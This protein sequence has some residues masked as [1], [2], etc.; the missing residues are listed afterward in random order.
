M[1]RLARGSLG[2]A[3]RWLEDIDEID[4]E[5]NKVAERKAAAAARQDPARADAGDDEDEAVAT[6]FTPGG[7]LTWT[8]EL[9]AQL[10]QLVAGR[11]A[12]SDVAG[13]LAKFAL[14]YAG[15]QLRRDP[16]TSADQA[17]RNG[18]ALMMT[19]AAEWFADRLRHGLG[20][21]YAT[22]L[23]GIT[24]ALD[25]EVVRELI[26]AARGAEAQID[27]NAND[28]ILLAATTTRWQQLLQESR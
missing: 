27:R 8:R 14:E 15:L 2:R 3:T 20:T 10:D 11:A 24:G 13:L 7:I 28:K 22:L 12:A 21:P 23:P 4:K 5:I 17:K 26:A 1:T 18:I 9:A 25:A 16:L 6:K 19:I